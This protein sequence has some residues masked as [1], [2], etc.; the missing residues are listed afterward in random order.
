[1]TRPPLDEPAGY[2]G[3][4][5]TQTAGGRWLVWQEEFGARRGHGDPGRHR[6]D[7]LARTGCR[8]ARHQQH[9]PRAG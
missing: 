8:H 1:M 7:G 4:I 3:Y 6:A 9:L 5:L 2:R